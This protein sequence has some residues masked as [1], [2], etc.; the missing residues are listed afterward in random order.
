MKCYI[1]HFFILFTL[2]FGVE[3][4]YAEKKAD[5]VDSKHYENK[6]ISFKYPG[7]WKVTKDIEEDSFRYLFIESPGEAI[8][9]IEIY[10]NDES[11]SLREFAELSID[12]FKSEL[13]KI[14]KVKDLRKVDPVQNSVSSNSYDR[15]KYQFNLN[16]I[17]VSIP[18]TQEY[19]LTKSDFYST[20]I[21]NQSADE[22]VELVS[23]G[24]E[25]LLNSLIVGKALTGSVN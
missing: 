6:G 4:S 18:H 2:F 16:G 17:G 1:Y 3:A 14:F 25:L 8:V 11:L 13:P 12:V 19:F 15:Y 23:G 5:L 24:F 10:L 22:D 9:R 21:M 7:N 20:F